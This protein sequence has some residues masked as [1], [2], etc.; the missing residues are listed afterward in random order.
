[1]S[2]PS[3]TFT[4]VNKTAIE[5]ITTPRKDK[6]NDSKEGPKDTPTKSKHSKPIIEESEVEEEEEV[7]EESDA[8]VRR[9][10]ALHRLE[11]TEEREP[12]KK[13]CLVLDC[14]PHPDPDCVHAHPVIP[15]G[16]CRSH[17]FGLGCDDKC[18][19]SHEYVAQQRVCFVKSKTGEHRKI[20]IY[21]VQGKQYM[22]GYMAKFV[23]TKED[24]NK[25]IQKTQKNKSQEQHREHSRPR[26]YEHEHVRGKSRSREQSRT[27][28]P[29]Y[30]QKYTRG[31][32]RSREHEQ[33]RPHVSNTGGNRGNQSDINDRLFHAFETLNRIEA[34]FAEHAEQTQVLKKKLTEANKTILQIIL[35]MRK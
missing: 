20:R 26:E 5:D 33:E 35:D 6:E 11:E 12:V 13:M 21:N 10:Q 8:E 17:Y 25:N 15:K 9:S 7:E 4:Q 24:M 14:Y 3:D 29:E 34:S 2:S 30:D 28:E 32:S 31:K 1:M 19:G 16:E 27:R 23:K 18:K 22:C